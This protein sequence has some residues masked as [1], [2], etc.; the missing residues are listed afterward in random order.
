MFKS[1]EEKD[2]FINSFTVAYK[3]VTDY[4]RQNIEFA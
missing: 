3:K 2:N 4:E 1:N